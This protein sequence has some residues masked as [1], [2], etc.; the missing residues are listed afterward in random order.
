MTSTVN[1]KWN[2][3]RER[4]LQLNVVF[5]LLLI[6][7]LSLIFY[8]TSVISSSVIIQVALIINKIEIRIMDFFFVVD[9]RVCPKPIHLFLSIYFLFFKKH[10]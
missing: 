10:F 5:S 8:G 9:Y 3:K 2:L 1:G 4:T 7:F 6:S